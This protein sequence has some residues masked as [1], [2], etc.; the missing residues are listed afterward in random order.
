MDFTNTFTVNAP[1]EQVWAL[2]MQP[3]EVTGCVPGAAITEKVDDRHFKGTVKVK[4][5]AVQVT[6]RGEMEMQPDETAH[7]IVLTGKGTEARGS[8]GASGSMTVALTAEGNATQVR[9]DSQVDVTGKV[10]T[11]G[12]GIMQD[13]ANRLTK[14]FAGCLASK[15]ETSPAEG[16][17]GSAAGRPEEQAAPPEPSALSSPQPVTPQTA[18]PVLQTETRPTSASQEQELRIADILADIARARAAAFLRWLA[19]RIEP[20]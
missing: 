6:Y 8:G 12:R 7:T 16:A 10:A 19:T 4:L 18:P 20:K 5:G 15:L 17:P 13:V 1:L 14:Q 3:E 11:F 9:I 2:L